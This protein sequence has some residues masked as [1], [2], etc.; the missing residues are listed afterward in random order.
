MSENSPYSVVRSIVESV[1]ESALDA[2]VE[3]AVVSG[4][5]S[6]DSVVESAVDAVVESAVV[7]GSC[8]VDSVVES[9]VDAVVES[10]QH[11]PKSDSETSSPDLFH[12]SLL[13]SESEMDSEVD[14]VVRDFINHPE[15]KE[16]CSHEVD[17][18]KDALGTSSLQTSEAE[19]SDCE[20]TEYQMS[21]DYAYSPKRFLDGTEGDF[22]LTPSSCESE[23]EQSR[24]FLR[25]LPKDPEEQEELEESE[26]ESEH[27]H[28]EESKDESESEEKE[29]TIE[30]EEEK[31]EEEQEEQEEPVLKRQ[32]GT[33][34]GICPNEIFD[35]L[36][37]P[38]IKADWTPPG[39][40][41]S[42]RKITNP[43]VA[44]FLKT[45]KMPLKT[46]KIRFKDIPE[47]ECQSY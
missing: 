9:A 21:S 41:T 8:S 18:C 30:T 37:C 42:M 7:F 24:Y 10:V 6:V 27:E 12:F 47:F 43:H 40:T 20:D 36:P 14:E 35:V 44:E 45:I 25:S 5:C 2:V 26:I 31:S 16:H 38:A 1:V 3:S 39:V 46:K 19:F 29:H 22:P 13:S 17:K 34:Y 11:P 15:F 33:E 23:P 4:S 32:K 28:E